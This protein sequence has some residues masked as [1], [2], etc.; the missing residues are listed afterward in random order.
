M[1]EST[2][3]LLALTTGALMFSSLAK[4][5]FT[6]PIRSG[7][8]IHFAWVG[9]LNKHGK[10]DHVIDRQENPQRIEACRHDGAFLWQ[11]NFGP[12]SANQDNLSP[13]SA[14][15]DVGCNDGVT[16]HDINGDGKAEVIIK[17]AHGV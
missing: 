12:N 4:A 14:T 17:I 2:L 5:S 3:S 1:K 11:V 6:V 8:G 9:D 15:I 10:I 7:G 13:G 16:V